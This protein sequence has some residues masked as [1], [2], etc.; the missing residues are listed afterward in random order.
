MAFTLTIPLTHRCLQNTLTF[1][2]FERILFHLLQMINKL[3]CVWTFLILPFCVL[4]DL[5]CKISKEKGRII[6]CKFSPCLWLVFTSK[7]PSAFCHYLNNHQKG[8]VCTSV[9][10]NIFSC[11]P[12][13]FLSH[14]V[15]IIWRSAFAKYYLIRTYTCDLIP[16]YLR[17]GYLILDTWNV[18]LIRIWHLV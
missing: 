4:H 5:I 18:L 2:Y 17:L 6:V 7:F 14:F 13:P 8:H 1:F 11:P 15:C 10:T 9:G 12:S 16:L 3:I